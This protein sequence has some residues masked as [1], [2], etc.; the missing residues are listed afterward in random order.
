MDGRTKKENGILSTNSIGVNR[1]ID[2]IS[3]LNLENQNGTNTTLS[4]IE[5]LANDLKMSGGNT[6]NIYTQ[7]LDSDKLRQI[8]DYVANE[9]GKV[10]N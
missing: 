5:K 2:A 10:Y 1:N 6:W 9:F 8:V 7:E 3:N 4:A